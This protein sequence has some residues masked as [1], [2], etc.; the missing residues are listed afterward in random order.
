[1]ILYSVP[2]I[3]ERWEGIQNLKGSYDYLLISFYSISFF[4]WDSF[5]LLTELLVG[6]GRPVPNHRVDLPAP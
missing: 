2:K 1:M 5:G 6:G 4:Q 3:Q